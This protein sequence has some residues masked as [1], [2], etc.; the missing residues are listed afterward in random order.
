LERC[1]MD[2]LSQLGLETPDERTLTV[3]AGVFVCVEIA[4][5]LIPA[6]IL[7]APRTK[8]LPLILALVIG[9]I[10]GVFLLRA[11][12][13]VGD[14]DTLLTGLRRG[15]SSGGLAIFANEVWRVTGRALFRALVARVTGR[16]AANSEGPDP[17][18]HLDPHAPRRRR[19]ASKPPRGPG[20]A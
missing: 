9:A 1:A 5:M 8:R 18:I 7:D 16:R 3:A 17:I 10:A 14:A 20:A 12:S 2:I 6:A 4:K 15:F 11:T 13:V 19:R